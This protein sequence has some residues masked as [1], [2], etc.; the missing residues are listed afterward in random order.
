MFDVSRRGDAP[1]GAL[2][3]AE[4]V[5]GRGDPFLLRAEV[6]EHANLFLDTHDRSEAMPVMC[7]PVTDGVLLDRLEDGA[8]KGLPG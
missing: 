4:L 8:W 7:H 2:E 5:V 3:L 1:A 6:H